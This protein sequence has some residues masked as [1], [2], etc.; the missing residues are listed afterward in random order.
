MTPNNT[1][2]YQ[3]GRYKYRGAVSNAYPI[4]FLI[5]ESKLLNGQIMTKEICGKQR[6][7]KIVQYIPQMYKKKL[8]ETNGGK[9]STNF[10][11]ISNIFRDYLLICY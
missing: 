6:A 7:G 8:A 2:L 11:Q 5:V 9:N 1:R 4:R 10:P 3:M